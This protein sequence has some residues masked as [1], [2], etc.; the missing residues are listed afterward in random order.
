MPSLQWGLRGREQSPAGEFEKY[1]FLQF[2]FFN[3][4]TAISRVSMGRDSVFQRTPAASSREV[5]CVFRVGDCKGPQD[6]RN[7]IP[8]EAFRKRPIRLQVCLRRNF[9]GACAGFR[10]VAERVSN[11]SVENDLF[12]DV[13][14]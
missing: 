6:A 5:L 10:V 14:L 2:L 13:V 9:S 4:I 8:E 12:W 3:S 11:R 1:K 7:R